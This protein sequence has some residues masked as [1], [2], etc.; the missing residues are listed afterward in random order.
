MVQSYPDDTLPQVTLV[1]VGAKGVG[2]S[3]FVQN[4]FGLR[5]PTNSAFVTQK[6]SLNT[7]I[8]LVQLVEVSLDQVTITESNGIKWPQS[9]KGG[10]L[11][12]VDGVL[13]LYD[14]TNQE[15]ITEIPGLL[16]WSPPTRLLHF[17]HSASYSLIHA[18]F[19][20]NKDLQMMP[21]SDASLLTLLTNRAY[22][23]TT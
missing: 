23:C 1:V 2:K 21:L 4:S 6:M 22:R 5:V 3:T 19:R 18:R 20:C 14:V 8:Y 11:P 13:A 16:R 17:L 7:V 10:P 15:S 9:L 12:S